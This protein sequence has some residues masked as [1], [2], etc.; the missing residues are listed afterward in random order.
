M[1]DYIVTKRWTGQCYSGQV[2]L[3]YGTELRL[4]NGRLYH[5]DKFLCRVNSTDAEE[6]TSRND[7]GHGRERGELV[8]KIKAKLEK[9]N[10]NYQRRWD[11][12]WDD[13]RAQQFRRKSFDDYWVWDHNF[14][15]AEIEDLQYIWKLIKNL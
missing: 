9:R 12:L 8:Q 1:G 3:R 14:F 11:R 5:G 13:E 6:H 15:T 10:A 7:D 4:E 2:D